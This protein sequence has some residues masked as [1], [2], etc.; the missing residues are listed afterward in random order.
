MPAKIMLVDDEPEILHIL[1]T[2]LTAEGFQVR[3]ALGGREAITLCQSESVDLTITD[4]KMPGMDGL[5]VIKHLKDMD[6]DMEFI[7]LTG[8]ATLDNA[9]K[10]LQT[11][12]AFG[13]L[14]K[15]LEDLDVLFHTVQQALEKRA[16]RLQNR[17]LIAELRQHRDHL[18]D[19]VAQRTAE[20]RQ[21]MEERQRLEGQ[22][23][24]SQK[25]EAIGQLAGGI[26]HD[27]NTL[28]GIILG[29]GEMLH[30]DLPKGSLQREN[31]EEMVTAAGRAKALV[32]QLLDFARPSKHNRYPLRIADV[33]ADALRLLR[34]SLPKT[35][36]IRERIEAAS[37]LVQ[38]N[39]AQIFQV[40]MNL[41]LNAGDAIGGSKGEIEIAL[42]DVTVKSECARL[43]AVPPGRYICLQVC[44]T[45]GGMPTDIAAHIFEPFFTTKEVGQGSGLGLSIVHGIVTSHGGFVTV[46]SEPGQGAR[47]R[48]YLPG[49]GIED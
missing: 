27:F 41:G 13:F 2:T 20:L 17:L 11:V 12:R 9:I 38:A 30:D 1:E 14:Q 33:V 26:A 28:L 39:A 3:K 25:M 10:A 29:Y 31:L 35:V 15:P 16:L 5:E 47:F 48:V 49:I 43:H 32:R 19:L 21:E 7:V 42:T 36:A 23:V 45:G 8:F 37:T 6:Q 24:Q 46:E 40:I 34:S 4:I 18:E 22:L 44:D